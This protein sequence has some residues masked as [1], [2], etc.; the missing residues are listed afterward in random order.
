VRV[1]Y[2]ATIWTIWNEEDEFDRQ[3]G[4]RYREFAE[5]AA[6]EGVLRGGEVLDHPS[7]ATVVRIRQGETLL[8]D[9]PFAE[10]KEQ[11]T[12]FFVFECENLDQALAMA[13]RIPG[14]RHGAVEVR[15]LL[16]MDAQ[17]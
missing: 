15:P 17:M 14:A 4:A 5:F 3:E 12:G 9:G 2:L 7:S 8:T 10:T 13:A 11:L 16:E 6:R 1:R